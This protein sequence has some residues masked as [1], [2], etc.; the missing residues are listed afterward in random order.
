MKAKVLGVVYFSLS[1]AW[2]FPDEPALLVPNS[3]S[4]RPS[5]GKE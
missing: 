2:L 4:V 1:V 5:Q 3:V